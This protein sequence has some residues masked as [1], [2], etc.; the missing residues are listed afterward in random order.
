MWL[1]AASIDGTVDYSLQAHT[2][3]QYS[4]TSNPSKLT[5]HA[6][7]LKISGGFLGLPLL[8]AGFQTNSLT[9][10]FVGDVYMAY[11]GLYAPASGTN[12]SGIDRKTRRRWETLFLSSQSK[13]CR[14]VAIRRSVVSPESFFFFAGSRL[15]AM[16]AKFS[17]S[18]HGCMHGGKISLP[19]FEARDDVHP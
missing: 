16:V 6:F 13:F 12:W 17:R 1:F 10:R 8:S 15:C 19:R 3:S 7:S 18:G 2:I 4:S 5:L 14:F 11:G 9:E